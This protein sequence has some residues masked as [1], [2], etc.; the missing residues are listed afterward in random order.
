MPPSLS[1]TRRG[2][3]RLP[4]GSYPR[5]DVPPELRRK[6]HGRLT[7]TATRACSVCRM[8]KLLSG[9]ARSGCIKLATQVVALEVIVLVGTQFAS[10]FHPHSRPLDWVGLALLLLAGGTIGRSKRRP[11]GAAGVALA[12]VPAYHQLGFSPGSIDL[13]LMVALF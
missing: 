2:D 7:P 9:A 5:S 8:A 11:I 13:A 12:P 6:Y 1:S 3:F 4:P 10:R